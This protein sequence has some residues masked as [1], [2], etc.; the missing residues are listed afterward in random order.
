MAAPVTAKY[1]QLALQVE[2]STPGTYAVICG[3]MGF[4]F[5]RTAEVDTDEVP[6]DCSDESL[7]YTKVREV[8][9]IDFG[10]S[11]EAKW[12]QQ[13]H[14]AMLDWFYSGAAKNVRVR[15][16]NAASGDTEYESG[17]ALLSKLSNERVKGKTVTAS[18]EIG[19]VG[20]P[21]R[22]AKP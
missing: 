14:E 4:T 16:T 12:A 19:F 18:I 15:H 10:V 2:T 3:M 1:E 11:G 7:P 9:S 13:S 8:R 6:A 20:T 5:D 22:S 21:A 17:P